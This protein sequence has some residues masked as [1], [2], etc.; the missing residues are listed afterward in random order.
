MQESIIEQVQGLT[1]EAIRKLEKMKAELESL[2]RA[3][4]NLDGKSTFE[5]EGRIRAFMDKETEIRQFLQ[6]LG[7]MPGS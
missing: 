6:K 7:M 3:M 2:N 5:V 1:P 4:Q